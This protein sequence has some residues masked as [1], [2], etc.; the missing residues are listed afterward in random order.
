MLSLSIHCET[1]YREVFTNKNKVRKSGLF[2]KLTNIILFL[3]NVLTL[4]LILNLNCLRKL[5]LCYSCL[6]GLIITILKAK[7]NEE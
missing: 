5:R 1:I 3:R 7:V 6:I 4:T 2:F